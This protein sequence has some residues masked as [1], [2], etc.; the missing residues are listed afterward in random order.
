M[1]A[2]GGGYFLFYV[3]PEKQLSFRKKMAEK[4]LVEMDW[5]FEFSGCSVVYSQ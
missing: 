5:Q 2:G 3:P 4:G 1:G